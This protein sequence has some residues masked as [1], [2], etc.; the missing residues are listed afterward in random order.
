MSVWRRETYIVF[1]LPLLLLTSCSS[2]K[3][4]NEM[5]DKAELEKLTETISGIHNTDIWWGMGHFRLTPFPEKQAKQALRI[6]KKHKA[7]ASNILF[8]LL[9][10]DDKYM[11]AHFILTKINLKSYKLNRYH[12]NHLRVKSI[13]N[14]GI[15]TCEDGNKEKIIDF[16]KQWKEKD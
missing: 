14:D 13:T 9:K 10:D 1:I 15:L 4:L 5:D 8:E 12:W 2:S 16:W 7:E 3:S 11:T 6:S